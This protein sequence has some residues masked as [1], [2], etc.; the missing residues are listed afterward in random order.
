[1]TP[2]DPL[3]ALQPLRL[4]EAIGAWP[5]AP[6]WWLLAALGMV[7]LCTLAWLF[8]QRH[9]RNRYRRL[10]Q[11]QLRHIAAQYQ[12]QDDLGATLAALNT[13]LKSVSLRVYPPREVASL[14]GEA[15]VD[16]LNQEMAASRS[17][18]HFPAALGQ[19]HARNPSV[20]DM[21]QLIA[22]ADAWLRHH[23]GRR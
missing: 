23:R 3:A 5:P 22:C 18:A 12:A 1:M 4:P 16:F 7:T 17:N 9:R 6:G 14:S 21:S 8:L 2:Q 11:A 13:L 10:A 19:A 15:W 20:T